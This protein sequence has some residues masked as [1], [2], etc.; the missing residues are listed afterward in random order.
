LANEIPAQF[1]IPISRRAVY[2]LLADAH[3]E[4]QTY[5]LHDLGCHRT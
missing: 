4:S 3:S 1:L 2:T 5:S